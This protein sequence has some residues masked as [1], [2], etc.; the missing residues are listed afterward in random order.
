MRHRTRRISMDESCIHGDYNV[1]TFD[2]AL[3]IDFWAL[4]SETVASVV[5]V[6]HL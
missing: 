4:N 6:M 5:N 3:K 1:S 2:L